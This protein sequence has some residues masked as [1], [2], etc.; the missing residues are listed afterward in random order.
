MGTEPQRD[1]EKEINDLR[2]DV[3]SIGKMAQVKF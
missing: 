3:T 1:L 2:T